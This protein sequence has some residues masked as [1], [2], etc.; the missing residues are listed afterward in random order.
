MDH[1]GKAHKTCTSTYYTNV[2][3]FEQNNPRKEFDSKSNQYP[4][5][6]TSEV[7]SDQITEPTVQER[8]MAN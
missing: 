3:I 7:A 8:H 4:T 2:R 1:N 5:P 6:G